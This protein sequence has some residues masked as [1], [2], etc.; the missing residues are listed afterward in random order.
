MRT[1]ILSG[2]KLVCALRQRRD[3]LMEESYGFFRLFHRLRFRFLVER[4][5]KRRFFHDED[6]AHHV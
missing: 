6:N 4:G 3:G 5:V 2:L 1:R